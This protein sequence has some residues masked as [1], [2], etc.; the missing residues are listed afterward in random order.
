M[1]QIHLSGPGIFGEGFDETISTQEQI[2]TVS[3][4]CVSV[5][6]RGQYP[7]V[8]GTTSGGKMHNAPLNCSWRKFRS[9]HS[10]KPCSR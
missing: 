8:F 7:G 5:I 1:G 3:I 4:G 6:A 10:E 2:H 9:V